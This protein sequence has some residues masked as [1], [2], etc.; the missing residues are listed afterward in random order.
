MKMGLT[1]RG[2]ETTGK[3]S[4]MIDARELPR[5]TKVQARVPNGVLDSGNTDMAVGKSD[6]RFT[7]LSFDGGQNGTLKEVEIAANGSFVLNLTVDFSFEAD[8]LRRYPMRVRQ[9]HD[10]ALVGAYTIELT[11]VKD[12]EDFFFGNPHSGELH[13]STCPLWPKINKPKLMTFERVADAQA[14]GYNGCRFCLPEVDEG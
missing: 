12:L 10:D 4:V 3:H 9:V 5:D 7:T 13:V 14:R 6:D 1:I 11:A 2:L 8:H